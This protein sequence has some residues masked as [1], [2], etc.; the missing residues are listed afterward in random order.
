M[1]QGDQGEKV[2]KKKGSRYKTDVGGT[3]MFKGVFFYTVRYGARNLKGMRVLHS[4][5]ALM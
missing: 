1:N 4:R 5:M 2:F 3:D